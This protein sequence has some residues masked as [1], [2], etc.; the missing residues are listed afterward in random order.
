VSRRLAVPLAAGLVAAVAAFAVAASLDGDQAP[1]PPTA[2]RAA[3]TAPAGGH[4]VFVRLG[5][6][7]CHQLAAA[8]STGGIGPSLDERLP[9]HTRES[10]RAVI[11]DPP[12]SSPM[13]E[14]FGSR[15]RPGELDALVDYLLASRRAG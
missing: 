8:G 14:D 15:L 10:L 11:V 3:T 13:P 7:S 5:C 12:R 2:A 4:A 1:A 9:G 6:G